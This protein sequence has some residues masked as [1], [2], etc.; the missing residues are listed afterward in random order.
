MKTVE[1]RNQQLLATKPQ[2]ASFQ[3]QEEWE[4]ALAGWN[5]RVL[6]LIQA[7]PSAV[8]QPASVSPAAAK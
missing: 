8:S 1:Q 4:E 3:S 5:Y 7:F 2:R 6:P